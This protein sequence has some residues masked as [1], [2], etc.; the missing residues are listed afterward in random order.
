M[1]IVAKNLRCHLLI[2]LLLLYQLI[3][4]PIEMYFRDSPFFHLSGGAV[5]RIHTKSYQAKAYSI[6][7]IQ[8][9]PDVINRIDS[10]SRSTS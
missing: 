10:S 6:K 4:D 3:V 8:I 9:Y 5:N 2:F 7:I 1:I